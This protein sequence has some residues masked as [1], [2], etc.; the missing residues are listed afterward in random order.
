MFK[1]I[2]LF[3]KRDGTFRATEQ[4]H[5]SYTPKAASWHLPHK[6]KRIFFEDE[7]NQYRIRFQLAMAKT[8]SELEQNR[9]LQGT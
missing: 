1:I 6:E 9:R 4:G 5:L 2:E 7:Q 8:S 3:V